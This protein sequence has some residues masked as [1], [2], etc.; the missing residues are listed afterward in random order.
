MT[1]LFLFVTIVGLVL[2]EFAASPFALGCSVTQARPIDLWLASQPGDFAIM[3]YPVAKATSGR[4]LY[5]MVTH[6]KRIAF[7]YGTFFPRGFNDQRALLES[8][9]STQSLALLKSWGVRYV[10]VG[11]RS[12]EAIN[13]EPWDAF[14]QSL[15]ALPGLRYVL[16]LDDLPIY[17]GDRLLQLLP[18][19]ERAFAVD[20]IYVYEVL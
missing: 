2:F 10:L 9:P 7:G 15:L 13:G 6:G 8:F 20:R 17:N 4:P 5:M 14:E 3:E 11:A 19:T 16:A 12:Y 1:S 18:G